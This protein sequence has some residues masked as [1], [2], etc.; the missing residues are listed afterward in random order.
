MKFSP[1]P[2]ADSGLAV[3]KAHEGTFT[4]LLTT[5]FSEFKIEKK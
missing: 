5:Y 4:L 1:L 3:K 2:A